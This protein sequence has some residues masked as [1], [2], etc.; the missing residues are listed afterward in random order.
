MIKCF[1]FQFLAIVLGSLKYTFEQI[2]RAL[3]V[4][5]KSILKP[6]LI[7]H[8][9]QYSPDDSEIEKFKSVEESCFLKLPDRFMLEVP[10]DIYFF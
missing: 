2:V 8:L 1:N 5:D 4:C 7:K 9:I 10:V 3:Y 6:E